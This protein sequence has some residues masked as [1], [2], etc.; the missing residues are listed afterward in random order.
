M[1]RASQ[2]SL[3]SEPGAADFGLAGIERAL[4]AAAAQSALEHGR[5]VPYCMPAS[6]RGNQFGVPGGDAPFRALPAAVQRHRYA[7]ADGSLVEVL[8]DGK[9]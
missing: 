1:E 8:A 2:E 5:E 7:P 6:V 4:V 9:E 3:H